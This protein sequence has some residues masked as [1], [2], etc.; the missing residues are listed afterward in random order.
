M[1]VSLHGGD[2]DGSEASSGGGDG[3]IA[4]LGSAINQDG[5]SSSLTAPHGPSQQQVGRA[6]VT[7][8]S[9]VV[10]NKNAAFFVGGSVRVAQPQPIGQCSR[11]TLPHSPSHFSRERAFSSHTAPAWPSGDKRHLGTCQCLLSVPCSRWCLW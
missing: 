7:G 2:G 11:L 1:G 5:R 10:S 3:G 8:C 9:T 4:V 6:S